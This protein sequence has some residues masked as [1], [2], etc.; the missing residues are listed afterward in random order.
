LNEE[1]MEYV[2]RT[3]VIL[4]LYANSFIMGYIVGKGKSKDSK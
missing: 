3:V 2:F 4:L 1:I